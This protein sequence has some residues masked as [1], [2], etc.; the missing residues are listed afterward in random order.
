MPK[1]QF[2]D[3]QSSPPTGKCL[4]AQKSE[5]RP[6]RA[7][8]PSAGFTLVELLVVC[9]IIVILVTLALPILKEFVDHAR[10]ARAKSELRLLETEIA[11]YQVQYGVLPANLTA[12]NRGTLNDPW[13]HGYVYYKIVDEVD[14]LARNLFG[15]H[16]NGDFDLC[17]KGKDGLTEVEVFFGG[18]TGKDDLL[19]GGDGAFLGLGEDW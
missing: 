18:G 8:H 4:P 11:D 14:P 2:F 3:D 10:G 19:R 17:S 7:L 5:P 9:A 12:I 13:G 6:G 16:L 15:I 1:D